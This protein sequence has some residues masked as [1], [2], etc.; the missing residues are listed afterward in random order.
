M[1]VAAIIAAAA[2]AGRVPHVTIVADSEADVRE[3]VL[4][5][6][7]AGLLLS[8]R[9]EWRTMFNDGRN[10]RWFTAALYSPDMSVIVRTEPSIGERAA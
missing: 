2:S 4:Q 6:L 1:T 7:D 5:L 3:R 8:G 9:P 10:V